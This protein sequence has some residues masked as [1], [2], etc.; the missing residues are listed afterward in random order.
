[1]IKGILNKKR[2]RYTAK[3]V[4]AGLLSVS[5]IAGSFEGL[6][7]F[8]GLGKPEKV[9]AAE[10]S[11]A[12]LPSTKNRVSSFVPSDFVIAYTGD[13]VYVNGLYGSNDEYIPEA[14][15]TYYELP[16]YMFVEQNYSTGDLNKVYGKIPSHGSEMIRIHGNDHP[17]VEGFPLQVYYHDNGFN[18]RDVA[19]DAGSRHDNYIEYDGQIGFVELGGGKTTGYIS[20]FADSGYDTNGKDYFTTHGNMYVMDRIFYFQPV[21]IKLEYTNASGG[22]S[23][24]TKVTDENNTEHDIQMYLETSGRYFPLVNKGDGTFTSD[25]V[26]PGTYNVYINYNGVF[27]DTCYIITVD[28]MRSKTLATSINNSVGSKNEYG[29]LKSFEINSGDYS[30]TDLGRKNIVKA[31]YAKDGTETITTKLTVQYKEAVITTKVYENFDKNNDGVY[32]VVAEWV[33][34]GKVNN[35]KT[36]NEDGFVTDDTIHIYTVSRAEAYSMYQNNSENYANLGQDK[37]STGRYYRLVSCRD[38]ARYNIAVDTLNKVSKNDNRFISCFTDSDNQCAVVDLVRLQFNIR[39]DSAMP[40]DTYVSL[41]DSEGYEIAPLY[42]NKAASDLATEALGENGKYTISSYTTLVLPGSYSDCRVFV[43]GLDVHKTLSADSGKALQNVEKR[44]STVDYYTI[45]VP[46]AL[47]GQPAADNAFVVKATNNSEQ[48]ELHFSGSADDKVQIDSTTYSLFKAQVFKNDSNPQFTVTVSPT[49]NDGKPITVNNNDESHRVAARDYYSVEFNNIKADGSGYE[50]YRSLLVQ[51][52]CTANPPVDP[53]TDG[54]SFS[55]WVTDKSK[56]TTTVFD[57]T[58]PITN[59]KDLYAYYNTPDILINGFLRTDK[60]GKFKP[61]GDCFTLPN[62]SFFGFASGDEAIKSMIIEVYNTKNVI[63]LPVASNIDGVA[64]GKTG[65]TLSHN[66]NSPLS[67]VTDAAYP[68]GTKSSNS[69]S[70]SISFLKPVS[71]YEAQDYIRDN[72]IF[73]PTK[74]SSG[75]AEICK[76]RLTASDGNMNTSMSSADT[77]VTVYNQTW[78]ALSGTVTNYTLGSGYYYLSG[79]LTCRPNGLRASGLTINGNVYI[80]LN[81]Y[82][83]TSSGSAASGT[84]GGGAGIYVPSGKNLYLIGTGKVVATGGNGAK[85]SSGQRNSQDSAGG[86]GGAGGGGAGAGIGSYGG[87]GGA[88]GTGAKGRAGYAGDA[89]TAGGSYGNVYSSNVT[90]SVAGGQAGAGG[91]GGSNNSKGGGGGGGGGGGAGSQ[92]GA[93]GGGGGGGGAGGSNEAKDCAE[94]PSGYGGNGGKGG[95]SGGGTGSNG[96]NGSVNLIGSLSSKRKGGAGGSGGS[97]S[98]SKLQTYGGAKGVTSYTVTFKNA[99]NG[100]NSYAAN[101]YNFTGNTKPTNIT[102][103]EYTVTNSSYYFLGWR[104]TTVGKYISGGSASDFTNTKNNKL[105]QPGDVISIPART[106]G[107]I[108]FEAKYKSKLGINATSVQEIVAPYNASQKTTYYKY[109]VVTWLDGKATGLD[110]TYTIKVDGVTYQMAHDAEPGSNSII[111]TKNGTYPVYADGVDTGYTVSG[112]VIS[113][114]NTNATGIVIPYEALRVYVKNHIPETI[115]LVKTTD[116]AEAV[117][118]LKLVNAK[119]FTAEEDA[120]H[121]GMYLYRYIRQSSKDKREYV[122]NSMP[123]DS[124]Y[125]L[126]DGEFIEAINNENAS[127]YSNAG[128]AYAN[129][130]YGP[131]TKAIVTYDNYVTVTGNKY[132]YYL[133]NGS[134]LITRYVYA[135][136]DEAPVAPEVPGYEIAKRQEKD[137][138]NGYKYSIVLDDE[139]NGTRVGILYMDDDQLVA[140]EVEGYVNQENLEVLALVPVMDFDDSHDEYQTYIEI[141]VE[142]ESGETT[143]PIKYYAYNLSLA[144]DASSLVKDEE[145]KALVVYSLKVYTELTEDLHSYANV[146]IEPIYTDEDRIDVEVSKFVDYDTESQDKKKGEIS[147]DYVIITVAVGGNGTVSSVF[148]KNEEANGHT[149]HMESAGERIYSFTKMKENASDA[150]EYKLYVNNK[151]V[152]SDEKKVGEDYSYVITDFTDNHTLDANAYELIINTYV[153]GVQTDLEF[154]NVQVNGKNIQSSGG[155]KYEFHAVSMDQSSVFKV[156]TDRGDDDSRVELPQK[157]F[158]ASTSGTVSQDINFYT[159]SFDGNDSSNTVTNLPKSIIAVKGYEKE[160]PGFT[161][162]RTELD[163]DNNS[164]ELKGDVPERPGYSFLGWA[165]SADATAPKYTRGDHTINVTATKT[166]YAVWQAD[167]MVAGSV[168]FNYRYTAVNGDEY[169]PLVDEMEDGVYKRATYVVLKLSAYD[170]EGNPIKDE[171]DKPIEQL[172]FVRPEDVIYKYEYKTTDQ[173]IYLSVTNAGWTDAEWTELSGAD[174]SSLILKKYLGF[175]KTDGK[176]INDLPKHSIKYIYTQEETYNTTSTT[177]ANDTTYISLLTNIA[178]AD[179]TKHVAGDIGKLMDPAVGDYTYSYYNENDDKK[180]ISA[181]EL[182]SLVVAATEEAANANMAAIGAFFAVYEEY[183]TAIAEYNAKNSSDVKLEEG[184]RVIPSSAAEVKFS[185]TYNTGVEGATDETV[186]ITSAPTQEQIAAYVSLVENAKIVEG[187][188][189]TA[190]LDSLDSYE[191]FN[192]HNVSA[193][194]NDNASLTAFVTQYSNVKAGSGNITEDI[195]VPSGAEYKTIDK[196]Y[197]AN[198][199]E[200][201]EIKSTTAAADIST[202]ISDYETFKASAGGNNIT[203]TSELFSDLALGDYSYTIIGEEKTTYPVA[204]GTSGYEKGFAEYKA[205]K[206]KYGVDCTDLKEQLV[207]LTS[208]SYTRKDVTKYTV[209]AY[210]SAY[211]TARLKAAGEAGS[212]FKDLESGSFTYKY[213]NTIATEF[214]GGADATEFINQYIEDLAIDASDSD[215]S[216]S[217]DTVNGK[218]ITVSK[219]DPD[220]PAAPIETTIKV[221]DSDWTTAWNTLV[222]EGLSDCTVSLENCSY[223]VATK[224]VQI[225]IGSGTY[226]SDLNTYEERKTACVVTSDIKLDAGSDTTYYVFGGGADEKEEFT[227]ASS[228]VGMVESNPEHVKNKLVEYNEFNRIGAVTVP[229]E[230]TTPL[231]RYTFAN[232]PAQYN[233]KTVVYKVEMASAPEAETYINEKLHSSLDERRQYIRV[234]NGTIDK[235]YITSVYNQVTDESAVEQKLPG[236]SLELNYQPETN[237]INVIIKTDKISNTTDNIPAMLEVALKGTETENQESRPV[238]YKVTLYPKKIDPDDVHSDY[239]YSATVKVPK[240]VVINDM[241][242]LN[243]NMVGTI[244]KAPARDEN[245]VQAIIGTEY[246]FDG[247]EDGTVTTIKGKLTEKKYAIT[248]ETDIPADVTNMPYA[249]SENKTYVFPNKDYSVPTNVPVRLGY[250]FTGWEIVGDLDTTKYQAGDVIESISEDITLKATWKKITYTISY[251]GMDKA[252]DKSNTTKYPVS[253]DFSETENLTIAAAARTGYIFAGWDVAGTTFTTNEDNSIIIPLNKL[254]NVTLTAKWRTASVVGISYVNMEEG[255]CVEVVGGVE[256]P[257]SR[258][259]FYSERTPQKIPVARRTG[260]TFM[261]WKMTVVDGSIQKTTWL[262]T[263]S[264]LLT[265]GAPYIRGENVENEGGG[266]YTGTAK[267]TGKDL[268]NQPRHIPSDTL[269]ADTII[270]EAVWQPNVYNVSYKSQDYWNPSLILAEGAIG[271]PVVF[272]ADDTKVTTHTYDTEDSVPNPTNSNQYYLFDGWIFEGQTEKRMDAVIGKREYTG[273]FYITA[274][275]IPQ[276]WKI[277]Y[278]TNKDSDGNEVT[279]AVFATDNP[280]VYYYNQNWTSQTDYPNTNHIVNP[281]R[282]GYKFAGWQVVEEYDV[283][284]PKIT[285]VE[286]EDALAPDT[287]KYILSEDEGELKTIRRVLDDTDSHLKFVA[288]VYDPIK[289]AEDE[290]ID[291]N[292][293]LGYLEIKDAFV[294]A[295]DPS[296]IKEATAFNALPEIEKE[297]YF[298]NQNYYVRSDEN[299]DARIV[300]TAKWVPIEFNLVYN[301][302]YEVKYD[303]PGVTA[304]N[305]VYNGSWSFEKTARPSGSKFDGETDNLI[306]PKK[307][308]IDLKLYGFTE[309]KLPKMDGYSFTGWSDAKPPYIINS[310]SVGSGTTET[311]LPEEEYYIKSSFFNPATAVYT[312][313]GEFHGSKLKLYAV[314]EE[315]VRLSGD[316]DF[317]HSLPDIYDGSDINA[318]VDADNVIPEYIELS[319]HR[320]N[321]ESGKDVDTTASWITT[322]YDGEKTVRLP[323]G[324]I[325]YD[326]SPLTSHTTYDFGTYPRSEL[327]HNADGTYTLNIY[328]YTIEATYITNYIA[329]RELTIYPGQVNFKE[330]YAQD[331]F[332]ANWEFELIQGRADADVIPTALLVVP[333]YKNENNE[334]VEIKPTLKEDGSIDFTNNYLIRLDYNATK[335]NYTATKTLPRAKDMDPNSPERVYQFKVVAATKDVALGEALDTATWTLYENDH[336]DYDVV[337]A[338]TDIRKS[339]ENTVIPGTSTDRNTFTGKVALKDVK[340]PTLKLSYEV[341]KPDGTTDTKAVSTGNILATAPI[342]VTFVASD[343]NLSAVYYYLGEVSTLDA[344]DIMAADWIKVANESSAEIGSGEWM[345]YAKAVDVDGNTTLFKSGMISVPMS[346]TLT[347]ITSDEDD[348]TSEEYPGKVIKVTTDGENEHFYT[349]VDKDEELVIAVTVTPKKTVTGTTKDGKTKYVL[350]VAPNGTKTFV[351]YLINDD[352]SETPTDNPVPDNIKELLLDELKGNGT[353]DGFKFKYELTN[354]SPKDVITEISQKLPDGEAT[355]T[356]KADGKDELIYETT[357]STGQK[358]YYKYEPSIDG[359]PV[360][361]VSTNGTDF[362]PIDI[363]IPEESAEYEDLLQKLETEYNTLKDKRN[364]LNGNEPQPEPLIEKKSSEVKYIVDLKNQ[365]ITGTDSEGNKYEYDAKTGEV[366]GKDKSGKPISDP[367]KLTEMQ[368]KFENRKTGTVEDYV[369]EDG[370]KYDITYDFTTP[371]TPVITPVLKDTPGEGEGQATLEENLKKK[372]LGTDDNK[373]KVVVRFKD[374]DGKEFE[375]DVT[376]HKISYTDPNGDTYV[377]DT[378][379]GDLTKNGTPSGDTDVKTLLEDKKK[380]VN[381]R[382]DG[383]IVLGGSGDPIYDDQGNVIGKDTYPGDYTVVVVDKNGNETTL[384]KL[385]MNS[386]PRFNDDEFE[387]DTNPNGWKPSGTNELTRT[388]ADG[389]VETIE[390]EALINPDPTDAS[391][392]SILTSLFHKSTVKEADAPSIQVTSSV[393]DMIWAILNAN[394]ADS[395]M[396][397]AI[398]AVNDALVNLVN[399]DSGKEIDVN[400]VTS[401]DNLSEPEVPKHELIMFLKRYESEVQHSDIPESQ[402]RI[403]YFDIS[404]AAKI[405][406]RTYVGEVMTNSKTEVYPLTDLDSKINLSID[407]PNNLRGNNEYMVLRYHGDEI[408]PASAGW[409]DVVN[410]KIAFSSDKFSTY[411]IVMRPKNNSNSPAGDPTPDDDDDDNDDNKLEPESTTQET[412]T[413]DAQNPE[414]NSNANVVPIPNANNEAS[415]SNEDSTEVVS[416]P[417]EENTTASDDKNVTPGDKDETETT[418]PDNENPSESANNENITDKDKDSKNKGEF[419]ILNIILVILMAAFAFLTFSKRS[420]LWIVN[421]CGTLISLVLLIVVSRFGRI[422]F[423]NAWTIAFAAIAIAMIVFNVVVA[424]KNHDEKR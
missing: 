51:K 174:Y 169:L 57:F 159:V 286:D 168:K 253:F 155:G 319:I 302:D 347:G 306:V 29:E 411:A 137:D 10:V 47:N 404:M 366:V 317:V 196:P 170:T 156:T 60:Y 142:S 340:E 384:Q 126:I 238:E 117:P 201:L 90:M 354:S 132:T 103:P 62:V 203:I 153:D 160:L 299:T 70:I 294:T 419:A 290:I 31:F 240:D 20:R 198:I 3:K 88:G 304:P 418:A 400:L 134:E 14:Y 350:E 182:P 19:R 171:N 287:Y 150:D 66:N 87:D 405:T 213:T 268:V 118:E 158:N 397:K 21:E 72:I 98:T 42:Y 315:D 17:V 35:G 378:V 348:E 369:D 339:Y 173:V 406:T 138:A 321:V 232:L 410:G 324:D 330:S 69:S 389:A 220:N 23:S 91:G 311:A 122:G 40:A 242:V 416:R 403:E 281:Q 130:V 36:Y 228:L 322:G 363:A 202:F 296:V 135:Y 254:R 86:N 46:I 18:V 219:P 371:T 345:L 279:D 49:V 13:K 33:D 414:S 43:N 236:T 293:T 392:E 1:M 237:Q 401:I 257:V 38:Y 229:I 295:N 52:G 409:V 84:T 63:F 102:V 334:F 133:T 100:S 2:I 359:T 316:I 189:I 215:T 124:Y 167:G 64:T 164:V 30:G 233:G 193:N 362:E 61:D 275:F 146:D 423:V 356:N 255:S 223:T 197:K 143:D 179:V 351:A 265:A 101:N 221:G 374:D 291:M 58:T 111:L 247:I 59:S 271:Y 205:K 178:D 285:Q 297:A 79:N 396:G 318:G 273:N 386:E 385:L 147:I 56:P 256:N 200:K 37:D 239:E 8:S 172:K 241:I 314:F 110:K 104:V 105:Y 234:E 421:A 277:E 92:Y 115:Q 224:T 22:T 206:E 89:G 55:A 301:V 140:G 16:G 4:L 222:S 208:F 25:S 166:L 260:Y 264:S 394:S 185:Y 99:D 258:V 235:Y 148:L 175:R 251:V 204:F 48:Y 309:D 231:A 82:T 320:Y 272:S 136:E 54:K 145:G 41:F 226:I 113:E 209:G 337:V 128:W 227:D 377:L 283:W 390:K 125:V 376:N 85:G 373:E 342:N 32:D 24:W 343:T 129:E 184:A 152:K 248:F 262:T 39:S 186:D 216:I 358:V 261:G 207:P 346:P 109:K 151:A 80:Y 313:N 387:P 53:Y 326:V 141:P 393:N 328:K 353:D 121:V 78:T 12:T 332:V 280:V 162:K 269:S 284:A 214:A 288:D 245:K 357:D 225:I 161:L 276:E 420:R 71:I 417:A 108:A 5:M 370:H 307:Y 230:V 305:N 412:T 341:K 325:D 97:R 246:I 119:P 75:V 333:V 94:D 181:P 11:W 149:Y 349:T 123:K 402:Y 274:T 81:G 398:I 114:S 190:S 249:G 7:T 424:T 26:F 323:I 188:Y 352:G 191:Y 15:P 195:K 116:D 83:L 250:N 127:G 408:A 154:A 194:I 243:Y 360:V 259:E 282:P 365:T 270:L 106:Y 28:D 144:G 391:S 344:K 413:P 163:K 367:A 395:V 388:G 364:K 382:D 327:V 375:A 361:T 422:V 45:E 381:V 211:V 27:E 267:Y 335:G 112:E 157:V 9:L 131:K 176:V 399:P 336:E 67:D 210:A 329:E 177:D 77:A 300:L 415:D 180:D 308:M 407:V 187:K 289:D 292:I 310:Q 298:N 218:I 68:L 217:G 34:D 44:M 278:V 355:L 183:K 120:A 212:I 6:F 107:N 96:S 95:S 50:R 73:I 244:K 252:L 383:K 266:A 65:V 338:N 76:V 380:A 199:E 93:G 303:T 263:N 74:N 368:K 312:E 139:D 331:R 372:I 192:V 379:T 165:E